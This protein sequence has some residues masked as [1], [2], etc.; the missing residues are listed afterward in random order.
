MVSMVGS[1][2]FTCHITVSYW[3]FP[4]GPP[5]DNPSAHSEE[6]AQQKHPQLQHKRNPEQ[7][8]SEGCLSHGRPSCLGSL[9]EQLS[10]RAFSVLPSDWVLQR[11]LSQ[12]HC[13]TAE[14][15]AIWSLPST[16]PCPPASASSL[17]PAVNRS[18]LQPLLHLV[19]AL[20]LGDSFLGS[21]F[22]LSSVTQC[23]FELG[24]SSIREREPG[25]YNFVVD[26]LG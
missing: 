3:F 25:V 16:C 5:R 17:F 8:R 4:H 20:A 22:N 23:H 24:L 6:D 10:L 18:S 12:L 9:Q 13:C 21:V 14:S 1:T 19:S 26:V 2:T 11:W 15:R 7:N